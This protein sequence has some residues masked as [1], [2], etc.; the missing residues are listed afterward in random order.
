M[1]TYNFFYV[2]VAELLLMP[3]NLL[4]RFYMLKKNMKHEL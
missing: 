2:I 1:Y 3:L 4:Q